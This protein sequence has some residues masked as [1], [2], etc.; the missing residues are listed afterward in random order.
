MG[1]IGMR[2]AKRAVSGI[3][4]RL[5][6]GVFLLPPFAGSDGNTRRRDGNVSIAAG[7]LFRHPFQHFQPAHDAL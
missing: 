2:A 1:R 6:G 5:A 3:L 7:E 4:P